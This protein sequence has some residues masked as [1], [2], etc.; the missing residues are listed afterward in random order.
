MS[1]EGFPE[2]MGNYELEKYTSAQQFR[3]RHLLSV[4]ERPDG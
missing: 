4:L 1:R 3:L 2:I